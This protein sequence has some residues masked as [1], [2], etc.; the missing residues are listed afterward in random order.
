M[1]RARKI[2]D[3]RD[4]RRS[5]LQN[6]RDGAGAEPALNQTPEAIVNLC[7]RA[8]LDI[9]RDDNV[10]DIAIADD[11]ARADNHSECAFWPAVAFRAAWS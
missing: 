5:F 1:P 7:S 4:H 9:R 8:K 11:I 10:P 3:I 2:Q 6:L